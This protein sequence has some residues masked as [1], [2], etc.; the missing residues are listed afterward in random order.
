[1]V[2]D[3]TKKL[4]KRQDLSEDEAFDAVNK[5]M[6]GSQPDSAI[7][8]FLTA[9]A[10]KGET[11]GEIT[12]CVKAM[13]AASVKVRPKVFGPLVDTC[14][15]G[16][17]RVKTF[18]VSTLSALVAASCGVSVAKHGNKAVTSR[19]GSAD[20]LEAVGVNIMCDA[21]GVEKCIE[22]AGLGFMFAPLFH[23]AMKAV[24]PVR[25]ALG[26]R[27]VFNILGP[28]SSPA[29]ADT[30][31]IGVFDESLV[32]KLSL[33]LKNLGTKKAL[34]VHGLDSSGQGAMDEISTIGNTKAAAVGFSCPPLLS[35]ADFGLSQAD[36]SL[37]A[38]NASPEDHLRVAS[39]ILRARQSSPEQKARMEMVLANSSAV[40]VLAGKAKDFAD[41][42][43]LAR[44]ALQ[45]GAALSTLEKF[46]EVSGGDF[47]KFA[48]FERMA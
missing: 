45:S 11:A 26:F 40:L 30:Q 15:T 43:G 17:D 47:A 23:P 29:N 5:L 10:A 35:P 2:A 25:K 37:V 12:G 9:L 34:V 3:Y 19:C 38:A 21:R 8:A 20:F 1:M 13:R 46:V 44:D 4:L 36:S 32:E 14:G 16:G 24:M 39:E 33:V 28:L 42:V 41:G 31:L 6:S 48:A 27:T 22:Q 18:N 7:A